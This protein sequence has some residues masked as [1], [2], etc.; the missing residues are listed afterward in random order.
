MNRHCK[1]YSRDVLTNHDGPSYRGKK[2]GIKVNEL[3][4]W[5]KNKTMEMT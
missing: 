5:N 2:E 1:N 3:L 4:C